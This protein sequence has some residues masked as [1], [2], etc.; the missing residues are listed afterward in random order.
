[1]NIT[2]IGVTQ[3]HWPFVSARQFIYEPQCPM[4][5]DWCGGGPL[6]NGVAG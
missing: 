1:M 4:W 5:I 2:Y 6:D 3:M